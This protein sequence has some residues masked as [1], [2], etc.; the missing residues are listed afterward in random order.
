MVK[1]SKKSPGRPIGGLS[2]LILFPLIL[3]D[4]NLGSD[5]ARYIKEGN[6]SYVKIRYEITYLPSAE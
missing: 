2:G 4:S 1:V 5:F 3:I 6:Y